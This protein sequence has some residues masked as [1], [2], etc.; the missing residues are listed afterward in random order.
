M[1]HQLDDAAR[2]RRANCVVDNAGSRRQFA[3]ALRTVVDNLRLRAR[4]EGG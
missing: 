3:A 1:R 4:H 2:A